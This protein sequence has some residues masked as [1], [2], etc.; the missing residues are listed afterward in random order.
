MRVGLVGEGGGCGDGIDRPN[1]GFGN[2]RSGLVTRE[3]QWQQLFYSESFLCSAH[4]FFI[5]TSLLTMMTIEHGRVR[6]WKRGETCHLPGNSEV[7]VISYPS[8]G[9][10]VEILNVGGWLSDGDL[11]LRS[12][13]SFL[14][15]GKHSLVPARTRAVSNEL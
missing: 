13:A 12:I 3:E 2:S 10:N 8:N 14:A 6:G 7:L 5:G 15:V 9:L 1:D 4:N 11:V